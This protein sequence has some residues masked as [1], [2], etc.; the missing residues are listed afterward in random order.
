MFLEDAREFS[1]GLDELWFRAGE[2]GQAHAHAD[3]ESAEPDD[4]NVRDGGE[5]GVEVVDCLEGFDLDHDGGLA[6]QVLLDGDAGVAG[7][8]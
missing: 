6:V 7:R 5:D 1:G 3:V 4:V 8:V 2:S